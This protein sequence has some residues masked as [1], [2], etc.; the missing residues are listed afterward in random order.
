MRENQLQLGLFE[1]VTSSMTVLPDHT[2]TTSPCSRS[3]DLSNSLNS[4]Y[5]PLNVGKLK[6]HAGS[7]CVGTCPFSGPR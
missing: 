3:S 1:R 5:V 6:W 7:F 2:S 4:M